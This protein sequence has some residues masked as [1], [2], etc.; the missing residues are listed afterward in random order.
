MIIHSKNQSK[1]QKSALGVSPDRSHRFCYPRLSRLHIQF[2]RVGTSC[3]FFFQRHFHSLADEIFGCFISYFRALWHFDVLPRWPSPTFLLRE[4]RNYSYVL[5]R[6]FPL[7]PDIVYPPQYNHPGDKQ[8]PSLPYDRIQR[9][10]PLP[11]KWIN[12]ILGCG[13][14]SSLL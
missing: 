12:F 9:Y 11:R 8:I 13:G 6:Y 10:A 2:G 7:C 5:P 14:R 3:G 4:R 1:K